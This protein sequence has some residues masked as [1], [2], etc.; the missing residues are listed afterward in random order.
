MASSRFDAIGVP[1]RLDV[2]GAH[3][4]E[5]DN[6]EGVGE[7]SDDDLAAVHARIER[8][9]RDWSRFRDDSLVSRIAR[10]SCSWRLPEDAAPML[11]L[12]RELHDLTDGRLSPLAGASLEQLGYDAAYRLEPLGTPRA[13]PRWGD[14]LSLRETPAGL[15]LDCPAP[16]LLDVGAAGKGYL[17][18][19]VGKLLGPRR[20]RNGRRC[21]RRP[22]L[23]G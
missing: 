18:D 11:D 20:D 6:D 13:A 19:L 5:H 1:W 22:A 12:Y 3:G 10:E 9:D 4:G 21:E 15:V 16:V 17:V 14:A 2:S 23:L 8:F 7:L